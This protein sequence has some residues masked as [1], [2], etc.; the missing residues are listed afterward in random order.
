ME[1]MVDNFFDSGIIPS[2]VDKILS[3]FG[4]RTNGPEILRMSERNSLS[5]LR[6]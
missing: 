1:A 4:R 3:P 5:W 6:Q 2:S